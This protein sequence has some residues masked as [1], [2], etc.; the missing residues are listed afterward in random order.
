M[1]DVLKLKINKL[2]N[3]HLGSE[4]WDEN[5]KLLFKNWEK[6]IKEAG[7]FDKLRS[8][9]A[10]GI[11]LTNI[12]HQLKD[13]SRKLQTE[14]TTQEERDKLFIDRKWALWF[15]G[16]FRDRAKNIAEIERKIDEALNN[17]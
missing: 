10:I 14:T 16:F 5:T 3:K 6:E 2:R 4:G 13:I 7:A 12:R 11:I 9:I 15:Q 8:D 17:N 1:F